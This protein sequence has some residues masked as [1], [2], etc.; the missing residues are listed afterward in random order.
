MVVYIKSQYKCNNNAGKGIIFVV[1]ATNHT[2][3]FLPDK[4]GMAYDFSLILYCITN[5]RRLRCL[6]Q[7]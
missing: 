7:D 4:N 3:I 2:V 1:S 5:C 6:F